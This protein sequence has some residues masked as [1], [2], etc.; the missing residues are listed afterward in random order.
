MFNALQPGVF[1]LSGWDLVGMLTARARAEVADLIAD[2]DTRWINRGAHDLMGSDRTRPSRPSK[3]PR[4]T[5]LYGTLPEQL[6]DPRLVRVA[7]CAA[8][9]S[10][11]PLRASPPATQI[12]VPDVSH[13]AMLVM[14]HQLDDGQLQITV[15]NFAAR[16]DHRHRPLRA[17]AARARVVMDMF[18]G[19]QVG[20][21][22]DLHSFAISLEPH[23]GL[24]LLVGEPQDD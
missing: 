12:D 17:P 19:I 22:D 15:L 6:A 10:P 9:S 2:G 14:V 11:Q 7:G 8:S 5:S 13:R 24:T 4:G 1:A 3:M 21:V 20:E 18:T 23:E 16:A